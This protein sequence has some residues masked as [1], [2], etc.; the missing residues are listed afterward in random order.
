MRISEEISHVL[1]DGGFSWG[2]RIELTRN[3]RSMLAM[4]SEKNWPVLVMKSAGYVQKIPA[5][6]VSLKPG[7]VRMFAPPSKTSIA[8]L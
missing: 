1:K 7:T 8:L 6:A 4:N 5:V 2:V 3:M